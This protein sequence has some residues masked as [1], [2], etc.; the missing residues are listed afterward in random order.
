MATE[1]VKIYIYFLSWYSNF[2]KNQTSNFFQNFRLSPTLNE[3]LC[4]ETSNFTT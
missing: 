1:I 4:F 3:Y 2:V